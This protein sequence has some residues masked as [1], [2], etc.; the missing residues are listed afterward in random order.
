[1]ET[2]AHHILIGLFTVIVLAL[3]LSFSLWLVKSSADRAYNEY[4]I[5]FNEAVTGLTKGGA[6][7]YNGIRVGSIYRLQLDPADPRRVIARIRTGGDVPIRQDTRAK[8]T[9]T[10]VTGV[11]VIQLSGGSPGSHLLVT[12]DGNSCR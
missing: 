7:Q 1:M 11:A 4:D 5:I 10:G 2:R 6:V 9:L 8:L 12:D 3:G